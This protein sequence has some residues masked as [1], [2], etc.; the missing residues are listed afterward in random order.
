MTN[1]TEN[2]VYLPAF[3]VF[4]YC[5]RVQAKDRIPIYEMRPTR[6]TYNRLYALY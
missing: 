2:C 1:F 3:V 5:K 4:L 6:F